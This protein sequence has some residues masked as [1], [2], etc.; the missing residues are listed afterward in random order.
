MIS[1]TY[2]HKHINEG[3][4]RVAQVASGFVSMGYII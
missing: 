4:L 1:H 3:Q 2:M